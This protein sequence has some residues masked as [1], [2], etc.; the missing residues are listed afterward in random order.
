[1]ICLTKE[2]KL[3]GEITHYFSKISVA[4]IKL[5]GALKEGDEIQVKGATTDFKQKAK[6]MQVEHKTIKSAK[7]G[8]SVGLKVK[9]KVRNGDSVYKL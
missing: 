6:S 7:K 1:M 9:D 3:I 8:D 5:K 4:V 2:G